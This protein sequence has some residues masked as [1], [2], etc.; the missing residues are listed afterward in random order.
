M[1]PDLRRALHDALDLVL[2]AVA[3]EENSSKPGRHRPDR[4]KHV[5]V[6]PQVDETT[7]RR[8]EDAMRVRGWR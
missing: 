6:D 8:V 5:P 7:K 2:D 4:I 1:S 3:K